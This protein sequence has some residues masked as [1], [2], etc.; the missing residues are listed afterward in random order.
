MNEKRFLLLFT[1]I[2]VLLFG[3]LKIYQT[4]NNQ[5]GII[6]IQNNSKQVL[7]DVQILY[8]NSDSTKEVRLG[9]ID[10]DKHISHIINTEIDVHINISFELGNGQK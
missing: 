7:Y 5:K 3:S 8:I 4:I 9:T 6:D 2:S 10:I 1:I